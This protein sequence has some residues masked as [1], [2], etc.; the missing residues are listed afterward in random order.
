M[1]CM[2]SQPSERTKFKRLACESGTHPDGHDVG[3]PMVISSLLQRL[4]YRSAPVQ[5]PVEDSIGPIPSVMLH[6]GEKSRRAINGSCE[7]RTD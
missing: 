3:L 1:L 7:H 5:L 2:A 4:R 6:C